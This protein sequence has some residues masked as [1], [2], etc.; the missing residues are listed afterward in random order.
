L[1]GGTYEFHLPPGSYVDDTQNAFSPD[2]NHHNRQ[3][4]H[5]IP[6]D[7]LSKEPV[8]RPNDKS[9]STTLP[10]YEDPN[11]SPNQSKSGEDSG[12]TSAVV[13]IHGLSSGILGPLDFC[14]PVI[15]T[16]PSD[17]NISKEPYYGPG[18][19]G[20]RCPSV[21]HVN[22]TTVWNGMRYTEAREL[23][24][25]HKAFIMT[26]ERILASEL[27]KIYQRQDS[28]PDVGYG[29]DLYTSGVVRGISFCRNQLVE[30]MADCLYSSKEDM[31]VGQLGLM[32]L[33][34]AASDCLVSCENHP[35]DTSITVRVYH[36]HR[37]HVPRPVV[38]AAWIADSITFKN[39]N[40]TPRE[41]Q[42]FAIIPQYQSN[43]AFG[44]SRFPSNIRYTIE[45]QNT[46]LSWLVWD[47]RVAGF[48]GVVPMY[49]D[50]RNN[51][52]HSSTVVQSHPSRQGLPTAIDKLEIDVKAV[53]LDISDS[54]AQYERIVRAHLTLQ[55]LP[56]YVSNIPKVASRCQRTGSGNSNSYSGAGVVAHVLPRVRGS[57]LDYASHHQEKPL[58]NDIGNH[59]H[60]VSSTAE[61]N[62]KAC[63]SPDTA[64]MYANWNKAYAELAQQHADVRLPRSP[65]TLTGVS[66]TDS[67]KPDSQ[68][69]STGE[70]D[71]PPF[72]HSID[73]HR[74]SSSGMANS[75]SSEN[76]PDYGIF[77]RSPRLQP[78]RRARQFVDARVPTIS[79]L[80][81]PA[82]RSFSSQTFD[83]DTQAWNRI[84]THEEASSFR[85]LAT[86]LGSTVLP[87]L[88]KSA[89]EATM[90]RMQAAAQF[91]SPIRQ[92]YQQYLSNAGQDA[93]ASSVS[94][95]DENL[96]QSM[97]SSRK[98]FARSSLSGAFPAKRAK[99]VDKSLD[100][101]ATALNMISQDF[102][103]PL[104]SDESSTLCGGVTDVPPCSPQNSVIDYRDE[105]NR[106]TPS[107]FL[108]YNPY[109]MPDSAAMQDT[110]DHS[111]LAQGS[112][113]KI[114]TVSLHSWQTRGMSSRATSSNIVFTVE[115]QQAALSRAEQAHVW[116]KLPGPEG[117]DNDDSGEEDSDKENRPESARNEPRLSNEEKK[118]FE[119]AV[120]R[121]LEDLTGDFDNIFLVD[122]DNSNTDDEDVDT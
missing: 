2:Y 46:P 97:S 65:G 39:L 96:P 10:T 41:G 63:Q 29:E 106:L 15:R 121:S 78:T 43:S 108:H 14:V 35:R 117:S 19:P 59:N 62:A 1:P 84:Q 110:N 82:I 12:Q 38:E 70:R 53:L 105:A 101:T 92:D 99:E 86:R 54:M 66:Y 58:E 113:H 56:W 81:P 111:G 42:E 114:R 94:K 11:Q 112:D 87:Q 3:N 51:D 21:Q 68:L 89:R 107:T 116:S 61:P 6:R 74:R 109:S 85:S 60:F 120:E 50:L 5:A 104:E 88:K 67:H 102:Y 17:P 16:Y 37:S 48:K 47:D 44:S 28:I 73:G 32:R 79:N 75:I 90:R 64:Q 4:R 72:T 22:M 80:P 93:A 45:S 55:V 122:S 71:F 9:W 25:I 115:D 52:G 69:C 18:S 33:Y 95:C 119:D 76:A 98:R 57:A 24:R 13:A 49:S 27:W 77:P 23:Y 8:L 40:E 100:V 31:L 103:S 30:E 7:W 91:G 26:L 34:L 36:D 20:S 83:Q 118:A